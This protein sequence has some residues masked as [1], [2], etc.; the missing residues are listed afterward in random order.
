MVC[1][2]TLPDLKEI[3]VP[4]SLGQSSGGTNLLEELTLGFY[5]AEVVF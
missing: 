5:L 3:E 1:A 2:L 4:N